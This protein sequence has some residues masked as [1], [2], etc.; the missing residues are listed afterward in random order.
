[1]FTFAAEWVRS[2]MRL[3]DATSREGRWFPMEEIDALVQK[4]SASLDPP[5]KKVWAAFRDRGRW[6]RHY[7]RCVDPGYETRKRYYMAAGPGPFSSSE[8]DRQEQG[9]SISSN[10]SGIYQ[11][12]HHRGGGGG[13]EGAGAGEKSVSSSFFHRLCLSESCNSTV[14]CFD[15]D[16]SG[17]RDG[18]GKEGDWNSESL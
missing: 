18:G 16:V 5:L 8:E 7:P 11:Q 14:S 2:E 9:E 12:Q 1:M 3:D 10:N 13:R 17:P 6:F 4:D 15:E